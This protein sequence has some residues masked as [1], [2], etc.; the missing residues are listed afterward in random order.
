M[1]FVRRRDLRSLTRGY[2]VERLRETVEDGRSFEGPK[3]W[4]FFDL[5]LE[6]PAPTPRRRSDR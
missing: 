5:L 6:K 3:H 4:H 1:T 2:R